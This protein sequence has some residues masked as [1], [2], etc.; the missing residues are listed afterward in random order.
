[1][2]VVFDVAWVKKKEGLKGLKNIYRE[3]PSLFKVFSHK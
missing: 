1:M 3:L 2:V